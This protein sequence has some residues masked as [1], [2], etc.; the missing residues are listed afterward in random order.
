MFPMDSYTVRIG[1]VSTFHAPKG[2]TVVLHSG[3]PHTEKG[4]A[5]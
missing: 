5:S 2:V 4:G 3:A 1:H